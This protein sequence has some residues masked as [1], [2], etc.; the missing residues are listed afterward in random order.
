MRELVAEEL[1]TEG[2]IHVASSP[3]LLLLGYDAETR[4]MIGLSGYRELLEQFWL[5]RLA[6]P[7]RLARGTDPGHL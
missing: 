7:E 2:E 3:G 6:D 5:I 1:L 4:E